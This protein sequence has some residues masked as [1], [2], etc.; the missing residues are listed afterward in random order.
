MQCT[1]NILKFW[2]N[3]EF[4]SPFWPPYIRN[5]T[6]YIH[7]EFKELEWMRAANPK[8]TYDIYLGKFKTQEILEDLLTAIGEK[9]DNTDKDYTQ[10]CLCA[11]KS[12]ISKI[13]ETFLIIYRIISYKMMYGEGSFIKNIVRL[14]LI[15]ANILMF[16]TGYMVDAVKPAGKKSTLK[17]I[18]TIEWLKVDEFAPFSIKLKKEDSSETDEEH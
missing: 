6:K 3:L 16:L 4:F 9:D 13:I 8:Y 18:P 12:I 7:N 15:V 11:L 1:K 17:Q 14:F 5:N 2:Y 10:S